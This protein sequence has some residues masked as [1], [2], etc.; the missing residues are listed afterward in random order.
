MAQEQGSAL[1]FLLQCLGFTI[2]TEKTVLQPTQTLEFLGVDVNTLSMEFSLPTGKLKNIRAESWKLL[3][4][5]LIS[6]RALSRLIGKMNAANKVIPL[7]PLF[8]RYLQM[9]LK[10]ALRKADQ[11]CFS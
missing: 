5:G 9:D 6:G 7:A 1:A 4:E 10:E 8:Y 3:R 11:Q 2:N